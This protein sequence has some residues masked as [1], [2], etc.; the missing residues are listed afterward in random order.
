MRIAVHAPMKPLDDPVPS[1]DR[2]MGRL[3]VRALETCGH[4][5]VQPTRFRSWQREGGVAAQQAMEAAARQEAAALIR[6]FRAGAAPDLWLTYHLYHKAPDWIGPAVADALDIPYVVVEAS[7][8]L[9][10]QSGDWAHG[11][12]A[13]DAALSRADAVAALHGDDAQG[14]APVVPAERLFLLPP[15]IDAAPYAR[16]HN[17]A[18]HAGGPFRLLTVAMMRAGDKTASYTVLAEALAMLDDLDWRLTVVG[19]GPMRSDIL[20][21]FPPTRL[22]WRGR[23]APEAIAGVYAE[24]ELFVWPAIREAFGLVFLEAQASGLPVVAGATGGVREIV[25]DGETGWL[26]PVGDAKAFARA[27]RAAHA[28]RADLPGLGT[29]AAA[30]VRARHDLAPAAKTL[31]R[32]VEAATSHHRSRALS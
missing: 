28:R 26:T 25:R 20:A 19:D 7:R 9:K 3:I 23:L 27:I 24:A 13:A 18:P 8:A 30:H 6:G 32:I 10:R 31:G 11:F 1:G 16:P 12:A 15:F 29:A 22:D 5:V 17:N 2:Q 14:L 4:A 21:L